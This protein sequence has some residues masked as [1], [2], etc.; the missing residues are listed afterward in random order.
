VSREGTERWLSLADVRSSMAA[1]PTAPAAVRW[2]GRPLANLV[3]PLFHRLGWSPNTITVVRAALFVPALALLA[4]GYLP[5][6]ALLF[7]AGFV[8]DC[9]DGNIARLRGQATYLGKFLDGLADGVFVLYAPLAVGAGLVLSGAPRA[10]LLLG[11]LIAVVATSAQMARNR[12][13]FFREWMT[14]ETGALTADELPPV[15]S[16]ASERWIRF[17]LVNGTVF[18]P[19]LLC[20]PNG[21]RLYLLAL[22]P[23]Q[24]G[25]DVLGIVLTMVNAAH[26]LRR[27]RRSRKAVA[28]PAPAGPAPIE[29]SVPLSVPRLDGREADYLARCISDGWVSS[30]GPYVARFEDKVAAYVGRAR[31]VATMNGTAALHLALVAAGVRPGDRVVVPDWTFAATANAVYLAGATPLFVDIESRYWG[32][33]PEL[34]ATALDGAVPVAAVIAVDPLGHPA[35][36]DALSKVCA[37]A[38][39]PLIEDAAGAIG[40]RV[41]GRQAGSAGLLAT[42]SF[43]GNKTITAGAGGMVLTDDGPMA[44]RLVHLSR[45]ART[46]VEYRHDAV[47]F[48]YRMSNLNAAVGLAQ[49]E[50]IEEFLAAKRAIAAAYDEALAGR[51]DVLP[52]PRAPWAESSCWLYSVRCADRDSAHDLLRHARSAGVEARLFWES[53]SGQLPFRDAPVLL[54]G[55]SNGLSGTVVSLPSGSGLS[56]EQQERVIGMLQS[57]RGRRVS[58]LTPLVP[59]DQPEAI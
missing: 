43:N 5:A 36:L 59:A 15:W 40:A 52:M 53:L 1:D 13:S 19:L 45:Q 11:A 9:V 35:E 39:V 14:S 18:S 48:N 54:R 51:E 30:A 44:D 7:Y 57:W 56:A 2:F 17:V 58:P 37:S 41:R 24:L 8:L 27:G 50:R 20:V 32:L 46:G 31:A 23:V 33:D 28:A 34:L 10:W 55:I 49:L 4:A 26:A 38:G 21:G 22:V 6:G 12:Y 47:G 25:S 42:L 16:S 29:S 3:T